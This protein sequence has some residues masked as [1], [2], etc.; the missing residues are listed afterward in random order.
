MRPCVDQPFDQARPGHEVDHV[1]AVHQRRHVEQRLGRDL[2]SG[3]RVLD[4]LEQLVFEHHFARRRGDGLALDERA[5]VGAAAD[6]AFAG[7]QILEQIGEA[8]DEVA[9]PGFVDALDH[10]RVGQREI[11]R[12]DRVQILVEEEAGGR[13]ATASS[14]PPRA[15]SS[16]NCCRGEQIGI[17]DGAVIR[18]G[19]PLRRGEAAVARRLGRRRRKRLVQKSPHWRVGGEL[20]FEQFGRLGG[21]APGEVAR[22][23]AIAN[24]SN[25]KVGRFVLAVG[26]RHWR[27]RSRLMITRMIWLV[28][29]RIEWT[30]R[31]RQKRSIG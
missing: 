25:G 18:V 20:D 21:E 5:R 28:P 3:R 27:S 17:A 12:A 13:L 11:A 19:P 29:S 22:L 30:R 15:T 4:Q 16:R 9:A 1:I 26:Q 7:R 10:R 8:L 24:G 6:D 14:P 31:S 23:R 2:V